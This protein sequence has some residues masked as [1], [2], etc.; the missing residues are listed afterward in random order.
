MMMDAISS[1]TFMWLEDD[2][3]CCS[4]WD[5]QEGSNISYVFNPVSAKIGGQ[6]FRGNGTMSIS[7][8]ES[9]VALANTDGVLTTFYA[10]TSIEISSWRFH[11]HQ[12]EYVTF[13]GRGDRLFAFIRNMMT[14]KLCHWILDPFELSSGIPVNQV[15][16]PVIG[17]TVLVFLRDG[18]FKNEGLVCEANGCE[19]YCYVTREPIVAA[20]S[21]VDIVNPI[22][23]SPLIRDDKK[24]ES[25]DDAKPETSDGNGSQRETVRGPKDGNKR[26]VVRTATEE[27]ISRN[28]SKCWVL[29][30]KVVEMELDDQSEKVIFS[31]VPE[32]WM[33]ISAADIRRLEGLQKLYI[34]PG[35]K[36]FVV[37]GM[38]TL[39]VWSLPANENDDFNLLFIWS[40]PKVRSDLEET[41]GKEAINQNID[42]MAATDGNPNENVAEQRKND[43]QNATD[44]KPSEI[45]VNGEETSG[46]KTTTNRDDKKSNTNLGKSDGKLAET[47]PV[48]EYYHFICSPII[49][50]DRITGEVEAHIEPTIG[51]GTDVITIPGEHSDFYTEFVNCARSIHLL[52]ACY[53]YSIQEGNTFQDD[54]GKTLFTFKEHADAIARF[55]RRHINRVLPREYFLPSPLTKEKAVDQTTQSQETEHIIPP[56]AISPATSAIPGAQKSENPSYKLL[57]PLRH[58]SSVEKPRRRRNPPLP[59]L[60]LGY[61]WN[62]LSGLNDL[63]LSVRSVDLVSF[64]DAFTLMKRTFE[65]F[66][67]SL[68]G[69]RSWNRRDGNARCHDVLAVL[70]LLLDE[71]EMGDANH[72]F[73]EGLFKTRGH[74]WIP[75]SSMALNPI[76][77]VI[78]IRNERLLTIMIDYCIKNAH[79]RHPGYLTP[80]IQCLSHLPRL[81]PDIVS[82]LFKKASYIPARNSE[83]V[84]SHAIVAT[85]SFSKFFNFFDRCFNWKPFGFS[86]INQ[87]KDPVFTTQSRL[88]LYRHA[89]LLLVFGRIMDFLFTLNFGFVS[90][91]VPGMRKASFSQRKNTKQIQ[92]TAANRLRKIYVS[93][94]QFKPVSERNELRGRFFLAEVAGKDSIDSPAVE[95]S[96]QFNW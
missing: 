70:T 91:L 86:D 96:L 90:D 49:F 28:G 2:G 17:T 63:A 6:N 50:H 48:G 36:R 42:R 83:Y 62:L 1:N 37:V 79:E 56:Q 39:Q 80:V 5:L 4:I 94:F 41:K 85:R 45:S 73:I 92:P 15:P 32:P 68:T 13:N 57:F 65:D 52:A 3:A 44:Q 20:R 31:F 71:D 47:E 33:R 40:R 22:D 77:R 18:L 29:G 34:L 95:A 8:D 74:A 78:D 16:V 38:Q 66:I 81:Y 58:E 11:G 84:A 35:G 19:I 24:Q 30:V 14:C 25:K 51:S 12:I 87:F 27:T 67:V 59:F 10:S 75:H 64:I 61:L 76:E 82:N 46:G 26:Y 72:V 89:N 69:P 23:A 21:N 54:L 93:P 60:S 55:T 9:M 88:H 53:A 7:P 43:E